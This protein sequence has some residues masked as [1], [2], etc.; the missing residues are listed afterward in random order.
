MLP[1]WA[2]VACIENPDGPLAVWCSYIPFTSPIV[3]MVRLP[4]GVPTWELVTSIALLYA[5]AFTFVWLAGRIY[6][7]GILMYGKKV[8]FMDIFRW[9][10]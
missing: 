6:R 7:R 1:L 10:K 2:G 8:S 3:M 4:Y 5:T 9:I